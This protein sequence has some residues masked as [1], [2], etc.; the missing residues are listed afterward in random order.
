MAALWGSIA[1]YLIWATAHYV[2]WIRNPFPNEFREGVSL[3]IADLMARRVNPF[4]PEA[5]GSFFYM[6]GFL[7]SWLVVG[8]GKLFG[9]N[10]YALHRLVSAACTVLAGL[11]IAWE[12][13]RRCKSRVLSVLSFELMMVTSWV[14]NEANARPDQLGLLLSTAAL[15]SA[16][17]IRRAW[18]VA[19]AALLTVA[20]FYAKQYF[21]I[22][23]LEIFLY[24]LFLSKARALALAVVT[25]LLLIATVVLV[26]RMY[27]TYFAMTILAYGEQPGS[28]RHLLNQM[29]AFAAFY[30]PLLALAGVAFVRLFR[31]VKTS[32]T[33]RGWGRPLIVLSKRDALA[34]TTALE[35]EWT[36]YHA[37][38]I[39]GGLALLW[40]GLNPGSFMSYFYQLLLPSTVVMGMAGLNTCCPARLR[41]PAVIMII[42]CSVF[43]YTGKYSFTAFLTAD[44]EAAWSKAH[45]IL[46][47]QPHG[48]MYLGLPIF[49]DHALR[50]HVR[51]YQNGH[52]PWNELLVSAWDRL[53]A[54]APRIANAIFPMAP[55][56][57]EKYRRFN[58]EIVEG[59]SAGKFGLVVTGSDRMAGSDAALAREY[60]LLDTLK[61][62]TGRQEI[63]CEFWIRKRRRDMQAPSNPN[64]ASNP[65]G[66]EAR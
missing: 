7:N 35:A 40:M 34:T 60:L 37:G 50:R 38:F 65:R 43:H 31:G 59:I 56:I 33:L 4:G 53:R 46:D 57:G 47:A 9:T 5:P 11:L 15:V 22:V 21:V 48:E 8:L 36:V 2:Y 64:G 44:Q 61:L 24:L 30:G 12:V 18:G 42:C 26:D 55:A 32:M 54:R 41:L 29:T 6:Y 13:H 20:A 19:L 63:T 52:T 66:A 17:R 62:S 16:Q 3:D 39:V 10:N 28:V 58:R 27:P 14:L 25:S 49:V 51:Y 23:G 1:I 45:A